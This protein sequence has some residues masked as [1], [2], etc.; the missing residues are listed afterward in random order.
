M[1]DNLNKNAFFRLRYFSTAVKF[2]VAICFATIVSVADSY[3]APNPMSPLPVG[4][5]SGTYEIGTS[6]SGLTPDYNTIKEAIDS[7]YS[8]GMAGNIRFELYGETFNERVV[9]NADS[10]PN[11]DSTRY[12]RFS[13]FSIGEGEQS[14]F[15]AENGPSAPP[16]QIPLSNQTIISYDASGSTDNGTFYSK[17]IYKLQIR[18]LHIKAL[19]ASYMQVIRLEGVADDIG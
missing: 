2:A 3:G 6:G 19:D 1:I 12:I 15:P 17:G 11:Y 7:L 18:G 4:G 13:T 10:I 16:I 14:I 8:K 9:I 5:L